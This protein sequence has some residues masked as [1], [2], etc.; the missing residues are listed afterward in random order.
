MS[1]IHCFD[2]PQ[3]AIWQICQ[4][5]ECSLLIPWQNFYIRV[6]LN[7]NG[8]QLDV[9]IG[10]RKWDLPMTWIWVWLPQGNLFQRK[11]KIQSKKKRYS[12]CVI[13]AFGLQP[14]SETCYSLREAGVPIAK[15][16]SFLAFQYCQTNH[17]SLITAESGES[18]WDSSLG[19]KREISFQSGYIQYLGIWSET[20]LLVCN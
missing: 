4:W 10:D 6:T 20:I 2:Q 1:N 15:T 5:H 7:N 13:H 9:N 11:R 19:N 14:S 12:S 17:S 8:V 18:N 3:L 16:R